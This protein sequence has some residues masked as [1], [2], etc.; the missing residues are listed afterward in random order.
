MKARN[1]SHPILKNQSEIKFSDSR[2]LGM[3]VDVSVNV[4][5]CVVLSP[6]L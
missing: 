6:E 2:I 5:S 3:S 1:D 4:D